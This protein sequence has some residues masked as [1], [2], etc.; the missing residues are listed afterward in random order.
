[1]GV[2]VSRIEQDR[3]VRIQV[4]G[5]FDFRVQADFRAAYRKAAQPGD[6]FVVDLARTEYLD[7]AALG[8]LLLLREAAGGDA[9]QVVIANCRPGIRRILAV[10]HFERL[11]TIE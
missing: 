6:R 3:T 4:E 10:A 1:M 7:S 8:M 5:R 9:A 2:M 11:F